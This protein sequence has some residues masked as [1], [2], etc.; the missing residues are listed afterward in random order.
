MFFLYLFFS[1]S[2]FPYLFFALCRIFSSFPLSDTLSKSRYFSLPWLAS[3]SLFF[4]L[5]S[6][7]TTSLALRFLLI[8]L[9]RPP[10]L[11]FL[12]S[13]YASSLL[14]TFDKGVKFRG[15]WT[16]RQHFP[17]QLWLP[18]PS[19]WVLWQVRERKGGD[20]RVGEGNIEESKGELKV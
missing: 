19:W 20:K 7:S 18:T 10:F 13:L 1:F 16:S 8:P 11:H 9:S 14:F 4:L 5:L 12:S 6:S 2:S 3:P 15:I 17:Q